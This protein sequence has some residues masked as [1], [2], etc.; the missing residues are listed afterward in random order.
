[1]AYVS[2]E[3]CNQSFFSIPFFLLNW[4]NVQVFNSVCVNSYAFFYEVMSDANDMFIEMPQRSFLSMKTLI[5][6]YAKISCK[7]SPIFI[8]LFEFWVLGF[9]F[10]FLF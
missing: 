6:G 4:S 2:L 1:M 3:N 8:F 5:S 10:L 9:T 7:L